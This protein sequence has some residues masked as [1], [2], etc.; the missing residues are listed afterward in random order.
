MTVKPAEIL[1]LIEMFRSSNWDEL[2]VEVD[3]LQLFLSRDP[4]ASLHGHPRAA[5]APQPHLQAA[6]HTAPVSAL[7]DSHPAPAATHETV[8]AHWVAV[9][10]PSLGT[11]YRAPKPGAAPFVNAGQ[12]VAADS[13]VCLLEVMKLFTTVKAGTAG[14]VRRVCAEDGSLVE[15][16]H[17]LF[18][19]EPA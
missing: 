16:G 6:A 8:P 12:N 5:S 1:T 15:F 17:I 7:A 9:T 19:V 14:V 10:A 4:N 3:G 13:E 18:Y 11:F 2:H